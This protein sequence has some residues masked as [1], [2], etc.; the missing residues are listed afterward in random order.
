M[1]RGPWDLS[2]FPLMGLRETIFRN[3][4]QRVLRAILVW[5]FAFQASGLRVWVFG[6]RIQGLGFGAL[7]L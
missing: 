5:I 3:I 7:G 4:F 6:D 2:H 1:F